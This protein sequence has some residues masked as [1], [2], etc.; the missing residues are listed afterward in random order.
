MQSI[1]DKLI[2]MVY[3]HGRGFVFTPNL[4]SSLGDPR[5]VG[6]VLTRLYRKGTIRRLA[7][8]LYDYPRKHPK[9]GLL[10]PSLDDVANALK[11][12]DGT[13]LQPSGAYAA[14]LLGLSNQ[15]PMKVV[16]LTDGQSKRIQLGKQE[17]ILKRTTPR[18]MATA[19]RISGLFIQA[20]RHIGQ[21]HVDESVLHALKKQLR[22]DDK[23]QLIKDLQYAPAWIADI[24]RNIAKQNGDK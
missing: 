24:M 12:R 6:T 2:S 7:R 15:V 10:S 1:D 18:N 3:G 21:K 9:L 5:V 20:L 13:R 23:K 14:N 16:F 8:G 4:F 11:G 22:E 17:I 19:G